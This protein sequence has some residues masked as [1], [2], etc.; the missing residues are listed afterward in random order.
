MTRG[1]SESLLRPKQIALSVAACL[2][3]FQQTINGSDDSTV[4]V[5]GED[6][7]DEDKSKKEF[8]SCKG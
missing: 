5:G 3:P 8:V 2:A 1:R 6:D 7:K 4:F